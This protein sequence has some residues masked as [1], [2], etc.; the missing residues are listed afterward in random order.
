MAWEPPFEETC[1][2]INY[3]VNYREVLSPKRKRVW[4]SV[5]VNRNV[6]SLTLQ[7]S[8]NTEYDIVVTSM[9]GYGESA[10]NE[11]KIWNFKTG[12]GNYSFA[13]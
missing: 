12:G 3:T 10:L 1:L 4:R 11:S 5:T 2:I 6:T 7:L 8:C 9:S 13:T